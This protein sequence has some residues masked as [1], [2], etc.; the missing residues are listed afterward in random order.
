MTDFIYYEQPLNERIRLFLRLEHL[1][2]S[3]TQATQLS[4]PWH[5]RWAVDGLLDVQE[6][7]SRG[8]VKAE[9]IKELERLAAGLT[10]L[11]T[12]P[13]VDSS[14]L[15]DVLD[16]LDAVID[17]LHTE[18]QDCAAAL[19]RSSMLLNLQRRH[20]VS[21][22]KCEF[23]QPAFHFWLEQDADR[24]TRDATGWLQSVETIHLGVALVL[25]LLRESAEFREQRAEAGFLQRGLDA[26]R[27][28]QLLRVGVDRDL[29]L[30]PEVSSGKHRFTI[31]FL[32]FSCTDRP[33]QTASSVVF[34]LSCCGL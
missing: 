24:R 31:R 6:L 28:V 23:D 19:N 18:G 32:E 30:F 2:K 4:S 15:Q 33:Q 20:N 14:R 22:G 8:D 11:E 10:T 27:P 26:N 12:A 21:G 7:L 5:S 9:L 29:D 17:R 13:N 3:I 16:D 34:L 25:R 1:F